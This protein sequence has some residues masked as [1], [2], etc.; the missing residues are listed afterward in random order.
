MP[1][2]LDDIFSRGGK[3]LIDLLDYGV[4]AVQPDLLFVFLVQEYRQHP[5]TPK[6]VTLYDVFCAPPAPARLSAAEM[7]PPRNLQ[8]ELALRP[9]RLNLDQ[10]DTARASA[11]VAPPLFLPPKF[12]FD[13]IDL[14]LREKSAALLAL[15]RRYRP[16]RTPLANLPGGK[17]N[18]SQRHFVERV[19][20]PK[21]RPWLVAAGFRRITSIA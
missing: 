2:D 6:A 8:I 7:L 14:H 12:L 15:Q 17:M 4:R 5:T 21:L 3:E 10:V 19:W 16:Q 18:A 1:I 20:E 9:L 11:A 13:A